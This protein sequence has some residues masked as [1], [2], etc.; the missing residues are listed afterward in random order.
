MKRKRIILIT[1]ILILVIVFSFL[2]NF[3][4]FADP[5][6][7]V[8]QNGKEIKFYDTLLGGDYVIENG[9]IEKIAIPAGA[10]IKEA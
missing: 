10:D 8:M 2:L 4:F 1:F 5:K 6:I 3:K 7:Y 9:K